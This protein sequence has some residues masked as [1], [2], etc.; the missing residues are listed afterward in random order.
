M[1]RSANTPERRRLAR[2]VKD[3]RKLGTYPNIVW[4][5]YCW[6][7][8]EYDRGRRAH[9]SEPP[10]LLFAQRRERRSDPVLPFAPLFGDFAKAFVRMRASSRAVG[11]SR[12]EAM[13]RALQFLYG[14]IR[15][16]HAHCDPTRLVRR[17][18]CLA[19]QEVQRKC[20]AGTAYYI[21]NALWE[22][23]E[24]VDAHR[25]SRT[26]IRFHNPVARPCKGDGVDPESQAAGLRK[27]P[28]A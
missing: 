8:T 11:S 2:I 27:M 21:G 4:E 15:N 28:S 24:F 22:I 7:I 14:A 1:I 17:H 26:R 20:A 3:A 10:R 23:A 18:F 19:V 13:V 9:T 25:L 6:D 12:Q 5:S 16:S